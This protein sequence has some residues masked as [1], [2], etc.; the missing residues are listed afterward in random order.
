MPD[1]RADQKQKRS[2]VERAPKDQRIL[3][4]KLRRLGRPWEDQVGTKGRGG[5]TSPG[6]DQRV[7]DGYPG[8]VSEALRLCVGASLGPA[9]E[10]DL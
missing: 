1:G 9:M 7:G 5:R 10:Q 8:V 6:S 2:R 4:L 3:M